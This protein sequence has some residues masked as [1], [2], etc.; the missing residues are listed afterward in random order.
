VCPPYVEIELP[1]DKSKIALGEQWR[2]PNSNMEKLVVHPSYLSNSYEFRA[3]KTLVTWT[4]SNL[5]GSVKSCNYH[6]FVKGELGEGVW[7]S[8]G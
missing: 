1:A 5:E 4:A 2:L 6:V 8:G 7:G 3:G